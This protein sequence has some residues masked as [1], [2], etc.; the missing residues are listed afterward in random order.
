MSG[1]LHNFD[2]TNGYNILRLICGA[3]FIPHIWA[4]FFVP[5]A[6]GFFVA[7][8]FRPPAFWLYTA[9]VIEIGLAIGLILSIYPVFAGLIAAVHLTVAT[10]AVYRVTGKWLWNIGGCEF[11]LFWAVCC[12]VVAIQA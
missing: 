10:I 9:C 2:L 3:F 11:P 6:L 1:Y 12:V 5:E 4:K 8:K 7:A